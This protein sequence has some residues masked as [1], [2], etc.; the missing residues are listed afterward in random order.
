MCVYTCAISSCMCV[1]A[2]AEQEPSEGRA[3]A[4]INLATR[5]QRT[6]QKFHMPR[7]KGK[8][9][10]QGRQTVQTVR[11]TQVRNELCPLSVNVSQY[12]YLYL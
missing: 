1:C 5:R 9:D 2:R 12:A 10:R 3:W 7:R 6:R 11:H 4:T 8:A